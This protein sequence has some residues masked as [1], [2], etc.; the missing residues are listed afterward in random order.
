MYYYILNCNVVLLCS[1]GV[2]DEVG[3]HSAGSLQTSEEYHIRSK[4]LSGYDRTIRPLRDA[5]KTM[6]V[7]VGL[8]VE[9]LETVWAYLYIG[10]KL[11]Y[12][13]T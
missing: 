6:A 7:G 9:Y 12:T 13:D 1:G 8:S 2:A 11:L 10:M 3:N 4:I 5:S